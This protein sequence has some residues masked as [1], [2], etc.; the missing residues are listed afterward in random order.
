MITPTIEDMVADLKAAGWH[1]IRQTLWKAPN[2]EYFRGPFTAWQVLQTM[3]G[4]PPK[5]RKL[6]EE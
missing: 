3:G 1:P 5:H 4:T 6:G 2:G